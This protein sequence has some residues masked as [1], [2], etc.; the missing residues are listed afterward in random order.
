VTEPTRDTRWI[1]LIVLC[2]G[3]LMIVLDNTVVNVALPSIQRDLG[4]PPAGLAWVV[5]AYMIAFGGLL[6]LAGRLGD[7]VGSKS[8]YLTGLLVFTVA[9]LLCG[10]SGTKEMLVAARF[11][12]GIGGACASAVI[13]AMIV[14]LFHTVGDR[15]RAMGIFSFTAAAGGSIGLLVGGSVTQLLNWH[16]VFLI[17]VP[18]G[19]VTLVVALRVL[20]TPAG[21]GLSG[22]ADA[23][24][25]LLITLALMLAVYTVVEI[26]QN[27]TSMTITL[28]L[29]AAALFSAFLV[30]QATARKP[31][32]PLRLLRGRNM[33]G[34]NLLQMLLVAAMFGFFFLDSL[35]LRTVLHYDA[36]ATGLAFLP[37]TLSIGALSVG[38]SAWLTI[39]FGP[40]R[41]LVAGV[42]L[43]ALG[44]AIF[45]I[46]P[47]D[48]SYLTGV[49]PGML[50]IGIGMGAS[51]PSIMMF[52]M[53]DAPPEDSGL[54]SGLVITSAQVGGALGLAVLATLAAS[55]APVAG[56]HLAFATS[57]IL[58][59]L[60][61][62]IA[63][64]VLQTPANAL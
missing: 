62:A 19:I 28:G 8:V 42:A 52:A 11:V 24:G 15:A 20:R 49:F 47:L 37:L 56:F 38:G 6:L 31:L 9:S 43:A 33:A 41:V 59:A 1:S 23:L 21:A 14:T 10:L 2:V 39:R 18:I 12:Q 34:S 40:R 54:A 55:Q 63:V 36:V 27:G 13:L 58:M 26:P 51:F 60:A 48:G 22:G 53:A 50:L 29:A 5:N 44:L 30:R 16:W 35:Y 7:L 17:N 57:A 32:L 45:A 46:A 61:A 3:M 25:A 64:T 4:F